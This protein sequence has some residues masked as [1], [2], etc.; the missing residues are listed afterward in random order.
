M[1][2][3]GGFLQYK[4]A[5]TDAYNPDS[6]SEVRFILNAREVRLDSLA[7]TD[8]LLDFLRLEARLTGTKEGCAEGDCGACTVLV[9]RRVGDGLIYEA[10]NACIRFLAT[11]DLCHVVTIEHLRGQGDALHPVQA[12]MMRHH[13]S[14]CG[15]CT[16][17]IVMSLYGLWMCNPHPDRAA[18]TTALQGNL[19]RCTG[20]A[21]IVR[22]AMDITADRTE[23]PLAVER[24]HI[25]EQLNSLDDGR[26]VAVG[27][28]FLPATVDGLNHVLSRHPDATIVAGATDVALW[29][30]KHLRPIGPSVFIGAIP[31]LQRIEIAD[32]RISIG[33]G[34]TYSA[35]QSVISE[36][37]PQLAE[38][39]D[40][41]GGA[42]V[43]NAG[44]IGGNI[45]NGSP[46]GDTPPVLIALGAEITLNR[47]GKRRRL[48]LE[49]FFVDY[50][51][52]DRCAGEFL[53]LIDI[54]LPGARLLAAEKI[55]KRRD[56]D[57]SA[58]AMGMT[59]LR[60]GER[61]TEARI[62]FGG[63][64]ATPK[65]ATAAE[66]AFEAEGWTE[67]GVAA[68]MTALAKD[69]A[70]ISDMRAS[71]DYRAVVARNLLQRVWLNHSE[72]GT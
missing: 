36:K 42:Q 39:W 5:M 33:A 40:R 4:Y 38:Y 45:A 27:D 71:A 10:V 61:I 29:V 24:Q 41:I 67:A 20:Y 14:Q 12:A 55:S 58:V 50:G 32:D 57:I 3:V 48:P 34:V 2:N 16:P 62:A 46:I 17:G 19:C 54:P 21:P 37:L 1:V 59:L 60:D 8:T 13:A 64:A 11:V 47:G 69:F 22:A 25:L 72:A 43:R 44:T 7:A 35:F 63:M 51:K 26:D 53:E 56:E 65:R 68:A 52:Q 15:F 9:G 31:E 66:Q 23:D 28:A 30:T 18:I 70:P 6:R 49:A